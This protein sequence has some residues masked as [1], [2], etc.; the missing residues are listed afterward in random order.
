MTSFSPIRVS[1]RTLLA[2]AAA[3]PLVATSAWA[4]SPAEAWVA[5]NVQKGLTILAKKQPVAK[6]RDEFR[7][8]LLALINFRAI[9][10]HVLGRG[11]VGATPAQIDEWVEVF[12]DFAE[13]FYE[14]YLLQ[15]FGQSLKVIGS[16]PGHRDETVVRTI[17]TDPQHPTGGSDPI[18]IDFLVVPTNGAFLVKDAAVEGVYLSTLEM[19]DVNAFLGSNHMSL[20]KLFDR[21]RALTRD[22]LKDIH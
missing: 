12:K 13:S 19:E 5:T 4:A 8:F 16:A 15:Y 14:S 22:K 2:A 18:E 10:I 9:A 11:A 3:T 21:F 17:L 7:T 20:P 1:R 6:R